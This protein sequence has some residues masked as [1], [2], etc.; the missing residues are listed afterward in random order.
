MQQS[1]VA[2]LVIDL[3]AD[4]LYHRAS[5]SALQHASR[6]LSR[7]LEIRVLTTPEIESLR[8]PIGDASAIVMGPGS[9]YR[10]PEAAYQIIRAAREGGLPFVGT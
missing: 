4:H 10:N 9:P 8:D 1:V 5:V 3:P 7:P 6:S 2:K